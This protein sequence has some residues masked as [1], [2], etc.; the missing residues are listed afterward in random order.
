MSVSRIDLKVGFS[1][2]NRCRF[3][4]Q[5]EKRHLHPDR[6]TEACRAL[7]RE[8]RV[9]ADEIVFTGG[10]VTLR[11]DLFE[12]VAWARELGFRVIQ[13]Q[14]NGRML[15]AKGYIE[16]LIEAGA[17][18]VS[19]AIHGPDAARHDALTRAPGSFR[20]TVRGARA[21]ARAGLPVVINSVITRA[22][23]RHLPE[24]AR[25]FVALG[26]R[27]FQFAFVHAL[28][29]AASNFDA[30]VPRLSEVSPHARLGLQVGLDAGV[31]CMTEAIPPPLLPA[32][33]HPL[34][35][36]VDHP[37]DPD[38]RRGSGD[39][40]LHRLPADRGQVQGPSLPAVS[41]RG[42]LRGALA[43]VP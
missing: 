23:Y 1:C 34:R 4:V 41:T 40:G 21:A 12:L 36:G 37:P 11:R 7:I 10:E 6:T 9:S 19:P 3:C 2:N 32:G 31:R 16:R 27:Q 29:A 17:T 5:G 39:R 25:L 20:Q 15:G 35:R 28:G 42:A 13:I 8:A 30:V 14:T 38:L 43:G 18:E 24:M 26:A 22:N 33:L